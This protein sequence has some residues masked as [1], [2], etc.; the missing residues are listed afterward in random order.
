MSAPPDTA[1]LVRSLRGAQVVHVIQDCADPRWLVAAS[2]AGA[3]LVVA[4]LH[5]PRA[6]DLAALADHVF[7]PSE[8][9]ATGLD[10]SRTTVLP[11]ALGELP[12]LQRPWYLDDRS[13][14]L[15]EVRRAVTRESI[16][17]ESLL[18]TG[19][20]DCFQPE[21]LVVGSEGMAPDHRV[22][23]LGPVDDAWRVIA[24]AD[25]LV[26]ARPGE[27][28]GRA[29]YE[30]LAVGV[31]PAVLPS[32]AYA[33]PEDFWLALPPEPAAAAAALAQALDWQRAHPEQHQA[34]RLAARAWVSSWQ[35]DRA[36]R[37]E[38]AW[39]RAWSQA[40]L[41][42]SVLP[43]DVGEADLEPFAELLD[44]RQTGGAAGHRARDLSPRTRALWRWLRARSAGGAPRR[45]IEKMAAAREFLGDRPALLLD[46]GASLADAGALRDSA[47]I[48]REARRLRARAHPAL[49]L[50]S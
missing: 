1:S 36:L 43:S 39:E 29:F 14:R 2:L 6:R 49:P 45:R 40:G 4:T 20:F 41:G 24:S 18:G 46:L 22:V 3:E 16:S 42:R 34:R 37:E 33:A 5:H 50:K 9:A 28:F 13:L 10:P 25:V 38:R 26:R 23:H 11:E 47:L 48:E 31:L 27:G 17:V 19:L 12:E 30:A 35:Q 44:A 21:A 8:W 32:P 7:V 15:V